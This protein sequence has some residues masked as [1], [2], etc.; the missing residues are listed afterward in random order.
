MKR[1][2]ASSPP[3]LRRVQRPIDPRREGVGACVDVETTGLSPVRDE[4]VELALVSFAFRRDSGRIIGI[5]DEYVGLREPSVPIPPDA[6]RIHGITWDMV[7]GQTLDYRRIDELLAPVEF[8]V[9]HNAPFDR[10][11]V[12]RLLRG[13][14][15]IPWYC[16]MRGINWAEKGFF[17]RRLGHLVQG[18]GIEMPTAH[19]AQA[20]TYAMLGLLAQQGPDGT[21]YLGELL[22]V[23]RQGQTG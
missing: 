9:A 20:D 14:L 19:R 1:R 16:T 21:S 7:E 13:P 5:V 8:L 10:G 11:F 18:H 23:R 4:V 12:E 6:V 17:S 2:G 22:G 3:W 15:P